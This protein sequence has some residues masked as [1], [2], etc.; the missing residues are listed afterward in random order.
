[1]YLDHYQ[2]TSKPFGLS[3]GPKFLWLGEKHEEALATLNYGIVADLGFLLLT[4]DVGVGKTA[5]IHRLTDKLDASTIVAHITDPG[6][7]INDFFKLLAS[8]FNIAK[9]FRS[10]ADFMIELEKFLYRSHADQ[11]KVLLVVDEAQRLNH[12]LL[13]QIRVLSNIELSDKKL[14]NIFFVGQPEFKTMLMDNSNRAIRQ[15]IAINYH[16]QPLTE[17][18]IG[19]YIEHRLRVAGATRKIFQP[20]TIP[21]IFRV[22]GGFPRA[23]N[24]LCDHALVTGYVSGLRTIDS[25]IIKE[26]EQEISIR[27]GFDFSTSNVQTPS[28]S[29]PPPE[30]STTAPQ[31]SSFSGYPLLIGLSLVLAT[32][33]GVFLL[34]P[35]LGRK[36]Q[37]TIPN[38]PVEATKRPID[39]PEDQP[40][41]RLP[42]VE[43]AA[44]PPVENVNR[45]QTGPTSK[46]V[47]VNRQPEG[48][49]R[50]A[51]P[52]PAPLPARIAPDTKVA[53][54]G[55]A[56]QSAA[57]TTALSAAESK[58][59][60]EEVSWSEFNRQAAPPID[61]AATG[62]D[63]PAVP[64]AAAGTEPDPAT[65]TGEADS[66]ASARGETA[67][68][69]AV[70]AVLADTQPASPASQ[71]T[72][73]KE[74]PQKT[75]PAGKDTTNADPQPADSASEA[76]PEPAP[77]T[78]NRKADTTATA[79]GKT[80]TGAAGTVALAASKPAVSVKTGPSAG[81]AAA[82]AAVA[83]SK[84]KATT[85]TTA[86]K[87]TSKTTASPAAATTKKTAPQPKPAN[88]TPK[89][90]P[91]PKPPEPSL[92]AK[93]ETPLQSTLETSGK[94]TAPVDR[95]D[96]DIL[97]NRLRSFLQTYCSTYAAKDLDTFTTYFA[98]NAMENGKPFDSLLPKYE[99]NFKFIESIQYR[100]ELQQFSYDDD[101][102]VVAIEGDFF[103]KWLLPGKPWR[104]NSG[105]IF[106]NLK[107]NGPAFLVQRLEY[108]GQKT[109]KN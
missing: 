102:E 65:D 9:D 25:N 48:I 76:D 15:R 53:A 4:G 74:D 54:T 90:A 77:A 67:A 47:A 31:R 55:P 49:I 1:M 70:M 3:P 13:D 75:A 103:L 46:M 93:A 86:A 35:Q 97:E 7:G 38:P 98:A 59:P 22:T 83:A 85:D 58:P 89:K 104:E 66:N 96:V 37:P 36:E 23:I 105:K 108:H 12:K 14:I 39:M 91:A 95:Q 84:P 71:T 50:P 72:R 88:P 109:K 34:W 42:K 45:D 41:Q 5:L 57:G 2:L 99:R 101:K 100:I 80:A 94:N 61:Q 18:E 32:L 19:Q 33:A 8:E 81:S 11:K 87:P 79:S 60:P 28:T 69:A 92:A 63:Q 107:E 30:T 24:V 27:A 52:A 17:S 64:S 40:P 73:E 16:I 106:M 51:P 43:T 56:K 68:S 78:V 10:K 20:D 21:E 82:P 29:P 44:R 62:I 6:L 26:C